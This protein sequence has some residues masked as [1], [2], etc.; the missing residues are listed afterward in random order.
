MYADFKGTADIVCEDGLSMLLADTL[1]VP[2]LRVNLLL[3]RRIC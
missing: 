2:G 3:A 1:Y